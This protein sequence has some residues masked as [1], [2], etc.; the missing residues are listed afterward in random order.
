MPPIP[1][2]PPAFES[3][4]LE[5]DAPHDTTLASASDAQKVWKYFEAALMSPAGKANVERFVSLL[6]SG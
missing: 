4:P 5:G 3:P 6:S 1:A 2:L